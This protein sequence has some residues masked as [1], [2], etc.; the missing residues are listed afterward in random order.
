MQLIY[1][2]KSHYA[3]KDRILIDALGLEVELVDAGNVAEQDP[4]IFA[5]NPLMKVPTLIDG[6][7]VVYESDHIAAYLVRQ[8]DP[9]DRFAVLTTDPDQLNL[10][11]V[12]NGVMAA[13]VEL[14]MAERTGIDTRQYDRFEKF[15]TTVQQG[16]QWLEQQVDGLSS[17]PTYNGFHLVCL[18]DHLV[19]Y[20]MFDLPSGQLSQ[21]VAELSSLP[22]VANSVPVD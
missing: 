16:L 10:R 3:R 2:P 14:V 18:W 17:Q 6:E 1:T 7:Q 13:E 12:M 20:D 11:A 21:R 8:F 15:R 22:Y 19:L 9:Q 4:A 5:H